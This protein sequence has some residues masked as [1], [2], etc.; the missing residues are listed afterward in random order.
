MDDVQLDKL[1]AVVEMAQNYKM[2]TEPP[3]DGLGD[4]TKDALRHGL[5]DIAQ[6]A[7]S[8]YVELAG[9][10]PWSAFDELSKE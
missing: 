1:G 10:D 5:E 2:Y 4:I 7:R 8:L 3:L 6:T 9:E